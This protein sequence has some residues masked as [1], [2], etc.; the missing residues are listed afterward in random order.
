MVIGVIVTTG[1]IVI[2]TATICTDYADRLGSDWNAGD[3]PYRAGRSSGWVKGEEPAAPV[4]AEGQGSI[5]MTDKKPSTL[6]GI[7]QP[8]ISMQRAICLFPIG[9]PSPF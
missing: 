3:R 9:R 2:T 5:R 4:R 8:T 6:D 1:A 7:D